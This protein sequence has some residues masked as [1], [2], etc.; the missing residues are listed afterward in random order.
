MQM[1]P[2]FALRPKMSL[3]WVKSVGGALLSTLHT[4][5]AGIILGR[6]VKLALKNL[7]VRDDVGVS[8]AQRCGCFAAS[9]RSVAKT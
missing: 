4:V 7:I 8:R 9:R 1:I 5:V 2:G 6:V 3:Y